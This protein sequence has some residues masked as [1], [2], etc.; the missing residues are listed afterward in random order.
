VS[1][2]VPTDPFS[3]GDRPVRVVLRDGDPLFVHADV[4]GVLEIGNPSDALRRLDEDEYALVSIDGPNGRQ[5]E[6]NVVTESGLYSLIL[7]SRKRQAKEFKRWVTRE[8]LP[9]IRRTGSYLAP[10]TAPAL[11]VPDEEKA[12]RV[13]AIFASSGVGDLAY[14]AAKAQQLAGRMLGEAPQYDPKT[15][16]L[17]VQPYLKSIGLSELEI[18]KASGTFGKKLK[19][20]YRAVYGEEPPVLPDLINRHMVDV[21]QYR[22]EHRPLFEQVCAAMDLTPKDGA[23]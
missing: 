13:I 21:A 11:P 22:E 10:T 18:R 17:T 20:A 14:W 23:A 5:I 16:P 1:A 7:G 15:R 3:F 4:C 9:S 8:V 19:A 6:V 2:L 12:A